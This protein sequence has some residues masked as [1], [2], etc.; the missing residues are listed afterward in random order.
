MIISSVAAVQKRPLR[1]SSG[2]SVVRRVGR[3]LTASDGK[4]GKSFGGVNRDGAERR[5]EDVFLHIESVVDTNLSALGH[6]VCCEGG[7][8]GLRLGG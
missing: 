7:R 1:Q 2:R 6:F 3:I 4:N 5:P 8:G